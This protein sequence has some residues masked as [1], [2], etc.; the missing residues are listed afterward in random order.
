MG[1]R[2]RELVWDGDRSRRWRSAVSPPLAEDAWRR[3][4]DEAR[5]ANTTRKPPVPSSSHAVIEDWIARDPDLHPIVKRLDIDL[6]DD[7]RASVRGQV[8]EGLLRVARTWVDH[9]DGCLRRL[10]ECRLFG[11]AE[12]DPPPPL[13]TTERRRYVRLTTRTR[14]RGRRAQRIQPAAPYRVGS[15]GS[16]PRGAHCYGPPITAAVLASLR[17]VATEGIAVTLRRHSER[18]PS[19]LVLNW[20][21]PKP[22][23]NVTSCQW[24]TD[25][26]ALRVAALLLVLSALGCSSADTAGP[27]EPATASPAQGA[28]TLDGCP[29]TKPNG[30]TPPGEA[31]GPR[32]HGNRSR[33]LWTVLYYPTLPVAGRNRQPD[34]SIVEKFPWWR[35]VSGNL[36]IRGR[37]I[38]GSAAPL[39]ARIPSGYGDGGFQAS[40]IIFPTEGCWRVTGSVGPATLTFVVLVRG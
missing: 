38:D 12:F 33:S 29:A 5:K 3:T 15:E 28:A 21:G 17:I 18:W 11:G 9:R 39:R 6:R 2:R 40:T 7:L 26:M 24:C 10:R 30:M 19:R 31:P 25:H 14:R 22:G 1:S 35:G 8:E 13:G 20:G 16:R 27:S 23:W 34:G 4:C 36:S 32:H 37:R